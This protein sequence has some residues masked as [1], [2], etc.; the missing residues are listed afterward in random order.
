M[1]SEEGGARSCAQ[2]GGGAREID[3]LR[4][5]TFAEISYIKITE[6]VKEGNRKNMS[7]MQIH[8]FINRL[9]N[10]NVTDLEKSH[11]KSLEDDIKTLNIS[12][13]LSEILNYIFNLTYYVNKYTDI[14]LLI[15][16]I[17]Y[18]SM[19]YDNAIELIELIVFSK[20][21]KLDEE[22]S[23][24][25]FIVFHDLYNHIE[26]ETN[27]V[28]KEGIYETNHEEMKEEK[29][30][31]TNNMKNEGID[32][33]KK[34]LEKEEKTMSSGGDDNHV[35]DAVLK[36]LKKIKSH[37]LQKMTCY[38]YEENREGDSFFFGYNLFQGSNREVKCAKKDAI[39]KRA[40]MKEM[41]ND[42]N[43]MK[44]IE[45]KNNVRKILLCLYFELI[46][47]RICNNRD[48]LVYMFINITFFCMLKID[49]NV[50]SGCEKK[51]AS[52]AS[53]T[54]VL[55]AIKK[56]LILNTVKAYDF[57]FT[58]TTTVF[59][60]ESG[61]GKEG[62]INVGAGDCEGEVVGRDINADVRGDVNRGVSGNEESSTV[63]IWE[64]ALGSTR[65]DILTLFRAFYGSSMYNLLVYL[66][67]E[68]V[69]NEYS[70]SSKKGS[71]KGGYEFFKV[72]DT[73][74]KFSTMFSLVKYSLDQV[75]IR[76]IDL[77]G[78]KEES[79]NHIKAF[80][81]VR[82]EKGK[83]EGREGKEEKG[84]SELSGKEVGSD[85]A[86]IFF[87]V[88]DEERAFYTIFPD[89]ANINISLNDDDC[90]EE[91]LNVITS[92]GAE[93]RAER[94]S[95]GD[96]AQGGIVPECVSS[97]EVK[98]SVGGVCKSTV[99]TNSSAVT[100]TVATT[101]TAREKKKEFS[102]Y[103]EKIMSMNK[104]KDIEDYVMVFLLNYNTKRKR[105]MIAS[106]ITQM[107]RIIL[108]CIPFY[109][110]YIAIINKYAKDIC[111]STIEELKK[112]LERCI[113]EKFSCQNRKT[114]CIKYLCELSKFNLLDL[115]YVLDVMNLLIE[116]YTSD[117]AELAFYI[118]ENCSM[119][120]I[121]NCKTHIRFLNILHKLKKM[122]NS[123]TL[124]P[125]LELVFEECCIKIGKMVSKEDSTKKKKKKS[126][127]SEIEQKQKYFLKKL[128]FEDIENTKGDVLCRFIRKYDWNNKFITYCLK[129]YVFKYL[130][131]MSIY[132]IRNL[133]SLLFYLAMYKPHFVTQVIDEL[134]ER[135]V[136]IIEEN[137]FQKFTA[138][139][140]YSH[141][142]AELYVHKILN[143]SNV[144]DLLYFL[145]SLSDVDMC[146]FHHVSSLYVL[147]RQNERFIRDM[148]K[149]RDAVVKVTR[150]TKAAVETAS[151]GAATMSREEEDL[152]NGGNV[153]LGDEPEEDS[154]H[155]GHFFRF[156]NYEDEFYKLLFI[157]KEN[158]IFFN[159]L[160][161]A[162]NRS[163]INIKMIC[164]IIE[165]CSKYF[166][167]VPL[168]KYKLNRYFLFF[169][170]FLMILKPLPIYIRDITDIVIRQNAQEIVSF[171]TIKE[172]DKCLFKILNCEYKIYLSRISR[173]GKSSGENNDDTFSDGDLTIALECSHN[174]KMEE[175][176][177][178]KNK[179]SSLRH[180]R[181]KGKRDEDNRDGERDRHRS[182]YPLREEENISGNTTER[183]LNEEIDAIINEAIREN[184]LATCRE[185]NPID[186]KSATLYKKLLNSSSK[187]KTFLR[188]GIPTRAIKGESKLTKKL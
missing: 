44:K 118:L 12:K 79:F 55:C 60:G 78:L 137:D 28:R 34:T 83:K 123:K 135:I 84:K 164:I 121:N 1:V 53:T 141:L 166:S 109:C 75:Q 103:L 88:N 16:I 153:P 72:Y 68:H 176:R 116:N 144:F 134:Y 105:K 99:A 110:R 11:L 168:L 49:F 160:K 165:R 155:G 154:I 74:K 54:D 148:R 147:F 127:W 100:A 180:V 17:K 38:R 173:G 91:E 19:N 156:D 170:R 37:V 64:E 66:Y 67:A 185:V 181:F 57:F 62:H 142:F 94:K 101:T 130:T 85:D 24:H 177:D 188:I 73:S 5:K 114:K 112:M 65:N 145:I 129:K 182:D 98:S 43:L 150:V 61:S 86:S 124:S 47:F 102:S 122:K 27:D 82:S 146:N 15:N 179:S 87:W 107:N 136:K 52:I 111:V 4:E 59:A 96:S 69:V 183:A 48:L 9:K 40:Y 13:Y 50:M 21:F 108:G 158:P 71:L 184:R 138:L 77:L 157:N 2:V 63:S 159:I 95:L 104:E 161:E 131:Y 186:F 143:S 30:E 23:N 80:D 10:T 45:K 163:F 162:E 106:T 115:S 14:F 20:F 171:K 119:L 33:S 35:E 128:L 126:K 140:Q 70:S 6:D 93:G 46:L 7:I 29:K 8:K 172:V 58:N 133:A 32:E 92:V 90:D 167:N 39:D 174:D 76:G 151:V 113:R 26:E 152:L 22:D 81:I 178:D 18:I 120:L 175:R 125:S 3:L 41:L 132:Q 117:H 36:K 25:F 51:E 149:A 187:S 139:I 89:F 31:I 42:N 97:I 169:I 56:C